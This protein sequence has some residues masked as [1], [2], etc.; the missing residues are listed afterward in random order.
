MSHELGGVSEP[1]Q[2]GREFIPS[3]L[4]AVHRTGPARKVPS[5][6]RANLVEEGGGPFRY[7]VRHELAHL[8]AGVNHYDP[9]FRALETRLARDIGYDLVYRPGEEYAHVVER[10]LPPC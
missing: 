3:L 4:P 9:G 7:V 8:N 1:G 6:P 10:R 5:A 2:P